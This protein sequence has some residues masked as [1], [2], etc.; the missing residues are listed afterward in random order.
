MTIAV[1]GPMGAGKS[2][3]GRQVARALGEPFADTDALIVAEH[4][5]IP[6]LFA[7]IG[8]PGFRT[9]EREVVRAALDAGGVVALGGGAVLDPATRALLST[10]TVVLLTV[11]EEAIGPRIAGGGRP[12][13]ADGVDSWRRI[14]AER[15]PVYQALADVVV[16]TSRRP[17][18]TIAAEL[19]ERLRTLHSAFP[20]SVSTEAVR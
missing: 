5:P 20:V 12:L 9:I 19:A 10:C 17:M 11:S 3:I 16:D 7:R 1:I 8:E 6:E 2:S 18:T 13:L 15:L 14:L 4:G